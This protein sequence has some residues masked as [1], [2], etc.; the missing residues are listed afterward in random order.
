MRDTFLLEIPRL[1]F[2][3]PVA[4]HSRL[5]WNLSRVIVLRV[6]QRVH[7]PPKGTPA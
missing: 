4:E 1:A 6:Q 2:E 3:A 7:F 5:L